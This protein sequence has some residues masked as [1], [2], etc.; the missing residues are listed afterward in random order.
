MKSEHRHELKTNEL[1]EWLGNF[2]EWVKEN[3][4]TIIGIAA[5]VIVVVGFYGWRRYDKNVVQVRERNEFTSLLNETTSVKMQVAARQAQGTDDSHYLIPLANNLKGFAESTRKKNMAALALIKEAE[6]LRAELHYRLGAI[7]KQ[8]FTE[9][10]NRA[11]ASYT[12]ATAKASSNPSL[13][14]AAKFG[15]GL[16]AE[17]LGD[18]DQARQIYKEIVSN[19]DFEGTVSIVQAKHRLENMSDYEKE[20]VFKPAPKKEPAVATTPT[21]QIKPFDVNLPADANLPVDMNLPVDINLIPQTSNNSSIQV[22]PIGNRDVLDLSDDDVMKVLKKAGFSD[23]TISICVT[24]VRNG[25]AQTG[26]VQIKID[27]EVE[28]VCAI[29][30]DD[31]HISSR[32]RG[33]Y[34]YN[35]KTGSFVGDTSD[36]NSASQDGEPNSVSKDSDVNVPVE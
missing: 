10:I 24:E 32:Q 35:V 8:D 30:I 12:E 18:F 13:M 28:L 22:L 19:T 5:L 36:A 6:T 21:I 15:L 7:S 3:S 16:C 14:A 11:K 26:A 25:L 17:E 20:I 27:N 34:I 4:K 29:R 1:A 2:P 9:Q 33:M 31:V 23:D